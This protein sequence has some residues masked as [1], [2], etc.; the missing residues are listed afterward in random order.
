[1]IQEFG[2]THWAGE[3]AE[4]AQIFDVHD[5]T[6]SRVRRRGRTGSG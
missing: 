3:Q 5:S 1:M 6:V 4:I 2:V